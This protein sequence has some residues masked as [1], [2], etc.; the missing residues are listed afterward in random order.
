MG[1]REEL[2][3]LYW[4]KYYFTL[5]KSTL[6]EWWSWSSLVRDILRF[7]LLDK[8]SSMVELVQHS[9]LVGCRQ[10]SGMVWL[11]FLPI[12]RVRG[13]LFIALTANYTCPHMGC[14]K[15]VSSFL[16]RP[17]A[18]CLWWVKEHLHKNSNP[19]GRH[20]KTNFTPP[21]LSARRKPYQKIVLSIIKS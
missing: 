20:F 2:V 16:V 5:F 19:Y 12:K 9:T 3:A 11:Y 4:W 13:S 1:S 15:K 17:C 14:R 10:R 7:G 21:T 18:R 6:S 8:A